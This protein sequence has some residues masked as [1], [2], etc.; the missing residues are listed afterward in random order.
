[1]CFDEMQHF[2]A[3]HT[4]KKINK[5]KPIENG[6]EEKKGTLPDE[7]RGRSL[8]ASR[9]GG[10]ACRHDIKRPRAAGI[11]FA[12]RTAGAARTHSKPG[13]GCG[14]LEGLRR[15]LPSAVTGETKRK[16]NPA[17]FDFRRSHFT[18]NPGR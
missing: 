6:P 7:Q 11:M 3:K 5:K 16:L 9:L 12:K 17:W 1:M 18:S 4:Q 14:S 2:I 10:G 15:F 8:C 13:D